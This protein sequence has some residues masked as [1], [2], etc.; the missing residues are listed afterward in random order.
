MRNIAIVLGF[1]IAVSGIAFAHGEGSSD[2][3][4]RLNDFVVDFNKNPVLPDQYKGFVS[5]ESV[6]IVIVH[7]DGDR[8]VFGAVFQNGQIT[9]LTQTEI[10]DPTLVLT[11]N[12]KLLSSNYTGTPG[13]AIKDGDIKVSFTGLGGIIKN[14]LLGIGLFLQSIFGG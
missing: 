10:S 8:E 13:Q 7:S 1:V 12:E 4:S 9:E 14:I 3:F 6:N 11:V 5:N 2:T